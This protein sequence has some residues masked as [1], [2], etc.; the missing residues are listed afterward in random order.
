MKNGTARNIRQHTAARRRKAA[1]PAPQRDKL[2]AG[3]GTDEGC[4]AAAKRQQAVRAAWNAANGF[5]KCSFLPKVSG[6]NT[7]SGTAAG[8]DFDN[9]LALLCRHY[10]LLPPDFKSLG[11]PYGAALAL[12][13]LQNQ[14]R[15][16]EEKV[17][18]ELV[19]VA[20]GRIALATSERFDTNYNL[21]Y[22]PVLP[23]YLLGR[24]RRRKSAYNLLLCAFAY[25][26]HVAD[27]PYYRQEGSYLYDQYA[28]IGQWVEEVAYDCW[29]DYAS[30]RHEIQAAALIGD[31]MERRIAN[32]CHLEHFAK[33]LEQFCVRDSF[34]S[35]CH[36]IATAFFS[37][38]KDYPSHNLKTHIPCETTEGD[39]ED[40]YYYD[41]GKIGMFQYISFSA[42]TAGGLYETLL[43]NV[44]N[45]FN[46]YSDIEEPTVT[47]VFDGLSDTGDNLDYEVR[48]FAAIDRLCYL[49]NEIEYGN[50]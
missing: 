49:L 16:R 26:Y 44:N 18:V 27:M 1:T 31:I 30:N 15:Y 28:Y 43:E 33:R 9:S 17:C 45:E 22:I 25:L 50:N 23:L 21:Y 42:G 10:G 34:D 39:Y 12:H 41:E 7:G 48:L 13:D 4:S 40:D 36:E 6:G 29:E 8:Q 38:W 20:S 32:T 37:L 47:R 24:K 2:H 14:F 19:Q 35:G 3:N 11:F 46:E 5:L